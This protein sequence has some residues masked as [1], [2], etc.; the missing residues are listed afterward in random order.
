MAK[1]VGQNIGN[2]Q[3]EEKEFLPQLGM[4]Y[5]KLKH[6]KT[7]AKHI[8]LE[9]QDKNNVF[10]VA[11]KTTPFDSTGV[12]HIL[13]HTAL[14]AS[15]KFPIRDPFFTMTRRSLNTFMN[16]FTASDWTMY[17]FASQNEK[18]FYNL[19]DVYL[20]AAFFPCLHRVD[21]L[22]EGHR[23]E[24]EKMEDPASELK[25]TGVVYNE[26]KGA[27]SQTNSIMYRRLFQALY[28]T[29]TY[30]FNSGG[31]PSDIPNLTYE[32][33]VDFHRTHYHPSNA[34]FFTYGN[35]DLQKHLEFIEQEALSKFD[36]LAVHTDVPN[37]VRYQEPKQFQFYYPLNKEEDN[38]AK[39]HVIVSWLTN[40]CFDMAETLSMKLLEEL[41]LG[42][43]GAPLNRA[44]MESGLGTK[45]A[46]GTGYTDDNRE[47]AFGAGLEGVKGE[48]I[49]KVEELILSTLKNI[50]Q[51]GFPAEQIESAIHQLEFSTREITGEG[52]PYGLTL[53]FR[54]AGAWLHGGS[55]KSALNFD[56][57]I[58][59]IKKRIADGKYFE[60]L[61][62]KNL[63]DNPHRVRVVL[64]PDH[65][66]EK[67][68]IDALAKKLDEYKRTLT[69]EQKQ[70]IVKDS[71][72]LKARQE[73][74]EDF[75]CLP[76]LSK[77]DLD[78]PTPRINPAPVKGKID[79]VPTTKYLQSTNGVS[80]LDFTF[81]LE[82]ISAEELQLAPL[83]S[84]LVT[85][86]GAGKYSYDQM[87]ERCS[88]Y[89]GG[90]WSGLSIA[91]HVKND[92]HAAPE[93]TIRSKV[94]QRNIEP[95]AEIL[96]DYLTSYNF[97]DLKRVETVLKRRLASFESSLLGSGH[98]FAVNLALRG[99]KPSLAQYEQIAGVSHLQFLKQV[100]QSGDY[101]SLVEKLMTFGKKV[102]ARQNLTILMVGDGKD[103]EIMEKAIRL[104]V[105]AL[106]GASTIGG[107]HI[108]FNAK[109]HHEAWTTTTPVSY[110]VE[111]F[112]VPDIN[113]KET[114]ALT[115][116]K[117]V[118]RAYYLHP[119][120][121]EKGGAYGGFAG[122][123]PRNGTFQF[124]SYRDP[125]LKRTRGIY[126]NVQEFLDNLKLTQEDIDQLIISTFGGL[127][128]P[129]SPYG[130]CR[131]E[132]SE[133]RAGI[134]QKVNQFYRDA[135]FNTTVEEIKAVGK[136]YL[137][138]E[139]AVVA[140]T[141][142]DILK[143][144]EVTDLL[145]KPI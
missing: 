70:S 43:A 17:P 23:Y 37:E 101:Q 129:G 42:H 86:C 112:K 34:Y 131:G 117:E 114:G 134:D 5:W 57:N 33:F 91:S 73:M 7:G 67:K 110:V 105:E 109:F 128:T 123:S 83:F 135:I 61:I 113:S 92:I 63:L 36:G 85:D 47:T 66:L 64:S 49:Q 65:E 16:A 39:N 124:I 35:L 6:L 38:G 2:Y 126:Q 30:G 31:E 44:L 1:S 108:P 115:I 90:I 29:T 140:I 21:F 32:Q 76:S 137:K 15:K 132:F 14:C 94:L 3:V 45:L 111:A 133:E 142:D 116:L 87:S 143:R 22:Q 106:K 51:N 95:M 13:E 97:S 59:L 55:P 119:E 41:L 125:H 58:E 77:N 144:D 88:R 75:S 12:A 62:A 53:F 120:I 80:Y 4:T 48:N 8:H 71:L 82:G 46:T 74:E 9:N 102:F 27:M 56:A 118:L 141:S 72:E 99:L 89:T 52:Y 127:D 54:F 68:Q 93:L 81:N 98:G 25:I 138:G 78:R 40:P 28:P 121:R 122:Y 136:K 79:G 26:M 24:F 145:V 96:F 69:T 10:G 104:K 103:L 130:N 18:D 100:V 50:S 139:S 19:L 20:N 60:K 11:F 84:A 107:V